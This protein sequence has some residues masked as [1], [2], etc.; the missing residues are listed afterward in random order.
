MSITIRDDRH[1]RSLTGVTQKQFDI[2]LEAFTSI[3]ETLRQ[4]AYQQGISAGTRRRRPG[5]GQGCSILKKNCILIGY[6]VFDTEKIYTRFRM[7]FFC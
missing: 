6:S 2:L 4:R 1:L 7:L 5:G 3:F